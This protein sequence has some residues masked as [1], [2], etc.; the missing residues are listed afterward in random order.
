MIERRKRLEEALQ[1]NPGLRA[2]IKKSLKSRKDEEVSMLEND[3]RRRCVPG[4]FFCRNTK[5]LSRDSDSNEDEK[6]SAALKKLSKLDDEIS[7]RRRCRPGSFWCEK[8]DALDDTD[9]ETLGQNQKKSLGSLETKAE[10]D[11]YITKHD[12][13]RDA[14][15]RL[16]NFI[17]K[18]QQDA[19]R[20]RC[21][22]G[23]F[24]CAQG[25]E[26]HDVEVIRKPAE[27]TKEIKDSSTIKEDAQRRRCRPGV[28]HCAS[29]RDESL[30]AN[31]SKGKKLADDL[32]ESL[33]TTKVTKSSSSSNR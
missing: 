4:I 14:F 21:R 20:R 12:T 26:S 28:F 10:G 18:D 25:D 1:E 16:L 8:G 24:H 33:D 3:P 7:K 13:T 27:S 6:R 15:D 11:G 30:S 32:M 2:L 17:S 31:D 22:P 23:L 9:S 5:S 29:S 19:P